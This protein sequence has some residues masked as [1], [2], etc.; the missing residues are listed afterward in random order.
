MLFVYGNVFA[1]PFIECLHLGA[2]QDPLI[3][4]R[5]LQLLVYFSTNALNKNANFMLKVL[6]HIILT[7]PVLEPEYRAY[8]DAIK[9]F[10]VESMLE[11]H[12]LAIGM[13]DH[14]LVGSLLHPKEIICHL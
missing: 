2:L 3:R 7:W 6:E 8:N 14:L 11:L 12:R 4:K 1:T 5:T 13:P 9:D 10:Q